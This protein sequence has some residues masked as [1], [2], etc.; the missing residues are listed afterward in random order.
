MTT[1]SDSPA[2][3]DDAP[4]GWQNT[5]V[6]VNLSVTETGYHPFTITAKGMSTV[7][8]RPE[9]AADPSTTQPLNAP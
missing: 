2:T 6:T 7:Y 8:L 4:G 9:K 5:A 3:S 1:A